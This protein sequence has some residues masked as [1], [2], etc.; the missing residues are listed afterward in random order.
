MENKVTLLNTGSAAVAVASA[1]EPLPFDQTEQFQGV[2]SA[3]HEHLL[4]RIEDERIDIDAWAPDTIA[5]YVHSHTASFVQEWRIP[6]NEQEMELVASA[7]HKELTGFGPLEDLLLDPTIEDILINGYKDVHISQGGVLRRAQQRFSDDRHLMRI[8]RRILAPL[9]RR[10]DDSNPMVDARLPNGGRLNA[11]IP[12]LAVDGPMVSIRKFRKD[13]F[14]P[15]ELLARGAFDRPMHALLSAMVL[16]RCNILISGGTS[17]GKTSLLNA[18]AS[19]IPHDER[20]V[21]IE[22]TA[23][24]ALNHPHVVRLESRLGGTDGNGTISI[25]ELVRNSLRMRPDRIVVGEVRGA[26]VLEMLQ[27]MNTGHDG[28]MATIHANSPRDCLYRMEMLAGFAGFQGSEESLRRQIAS[29]VDFIVQISRL[30]G[31]RR[32][33]LS[34][35]EVTGVTDNLIT[36]QELFRHENWYDADNTER[37]RW[38]GLGFHPHSHKLEPFRSLLRSAATEDYL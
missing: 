19:F 16:G 5:R 27:A 37:D 4:N 12:P 36:T 25:R 22:D 13:P 20:V 23:E 21:T 15:D 24:L 17:S 14:T 7:L 9:G 28:S 11:I 10:L 3:A 18:L 2:L 6:V 33:I 26:E 38:V 30:A 31:G 8:L 1:V 34:I 29:A 35:T 32:V